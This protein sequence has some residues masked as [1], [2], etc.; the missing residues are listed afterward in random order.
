MAGRIVT[1]AQICTRQIEVAKGA[2]GSQVGKG[3]LAMQG[4]GKA[5]IYVPPGGAAQPYVDSS[6]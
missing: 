2:R 6:Q 1:G 4:I 3:R 5:A